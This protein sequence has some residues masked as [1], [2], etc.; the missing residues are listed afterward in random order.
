MKNISE[1]YLRTKT[2][3]QIQYPYLVFGFNKK[4][5]NHYL[6]ANRYAV[7]WRLSR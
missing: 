6:Q 3:Y 5:I 7:S 1:L 2:C 4:V